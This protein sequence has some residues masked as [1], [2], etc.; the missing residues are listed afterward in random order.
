MLQKIRLRRNGQVVH[1]TEEEEAEI[2][3]ATV[4]VTE[5][6]AA[7]EIAVVIV[8]AQAAADTRKATVDQATG[9]PTKAVETDVPIQAVLQPVRIRTEVAA[10][11]Q[12]ANH[13]IKNKPGN[14]EK[15]RGFSGLR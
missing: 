11:L 4:A 3:V 15:R 7:A 6:D 9:Q 8:V 1:H 13:G 5:A 10:G 12:V 2:V 14:Q